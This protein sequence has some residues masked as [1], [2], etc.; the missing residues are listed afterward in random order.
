[1]HGHLR[2]AKE[3]PGKPDE[4]KDSESENLVIGRPVNKT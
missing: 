1:M 2:L 4:A 3:F